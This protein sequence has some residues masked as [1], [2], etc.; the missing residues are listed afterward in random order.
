MERHPKSIDGIG[1][2]PGSVPRGADGDQ[3]AA[4]EDVSVPAEKSGPVFT[5][6]RVCAET[7]T[8]NTRGREAFHVL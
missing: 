7:F 3:R 5:L 2:L 4:D 1:S 6:I 8:H